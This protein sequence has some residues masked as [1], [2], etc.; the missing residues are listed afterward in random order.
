MKPVCETNKKHVG[1]EKPMKHLHNQLKPSL[2]KFQYSILNDFQ[3]TPLG[4]FGQIKHLTTVFGLST[5]K[6]RLLEVVTIAL[7]DVLFVNGDCT[8]KCN[9]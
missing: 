2:M 5:M 4:Y 1:T 6:N 9:S 8:K 7:T 3:R